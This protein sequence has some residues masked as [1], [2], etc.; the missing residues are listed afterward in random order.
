MSA[1]RAFARTYLSR[2]IRGQQLRVIVSSG[3]YYVRSD[4]PPTERTI[5]ISLPPGRRG[6][7]FSPTLRSSQASSMTRLRRG[8]RLQHAVAPR[9]T[10]TRSASPPLGGTA[11]KSTPSSPLLTECCVVRGDR[12]INYPTRRFHLRRDD[13]VETLSSIP[14]VARSTSG[15]ISQ[16]PLL[17]VAELHC[18]VTRSPRQAQTDGTELRIKYA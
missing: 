16:C 12:N 17:S 14:R 1:G 10:V 3:R 13:P 18:L 7:P 4:R 11:R 9:L 8:L 5:N 2:G 6:S 15:R